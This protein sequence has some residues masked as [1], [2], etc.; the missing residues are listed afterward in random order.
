MSEN[1]LTISAH[2]LTAVVST[3]GAEVQSLRTADGREYNWQG[4]APYWSGRGPVLFPATGAPW[5]AT[6]TIDGT[7]YEMPKHGFVKGETFDVVSHEADTLLLQYKPTEK[8]KAY[9]PFDYVLRVRFS[10]TEKKLDV[11]FEVENLSDTPLFFQIG[12]HPALNVPNFD[13]ARAVNGYVKLH[14]DTKDE[15]RYLI[16]AREQGCIQTGRFPVPADERGLVPLC[17]ETFANEALIFENHQVRAIELLDRDLH[18]V[19][20]VESDAPC[21]LIWQMQDVNCPFV[22]FE[23]WYGLPDNEGSSNELAQRPFIQ[24]A[25]PH[26]TWQ[27]GFTV[28]L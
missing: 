23:P 7:A 25:K 21:W 9:Y 8:T 10:L 17:V 6:Y 14:G 11:R 15:A 28:T 26:A 12:G 18:H 1:F 20:T 27:G 19:A 3:K 22:C 24:Q 2:G 16:R 13:K 4:T 5:N